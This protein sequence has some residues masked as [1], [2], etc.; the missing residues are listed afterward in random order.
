MKKT[1]R[2]L[3]VAFGIIFALSSYNSEHGNNSYCIDGNCE[4]A[5]ELEHNDEHDHNHENDKLYNDDINLGN[6]KLGISVLSKSKTKVSEDGISFGVHT[7]DTSSSDE[8]Y[9]SIELQ[10]NYSPSGCL[11]DS[12]WSVSDSTALKVTPNAIDSSKCVVT[13]IKEFD[14]EVTVS[15]KSKFFSDICATLKATYVGGF[16]IEVIQGTISLSANRGCAHTSTSIVDSSSA[17]SDFTNY[18][19]VKYNGS[20]LSV[21]EIYSY[22]T[23]GDLIVTTSGDL[24]FVNNSSAPYF[25]MKDLSATSTAG[26]K[27]IGAT[28]KAKEDSSKTGS[29]SGTSTMKI[30]DWSVVQKNR[31]VSYNCSGTITR[32]WNPDYSYYCGTCSRTATASEYG[33]TCGKQSTYYYVECNLCTNRNGDVGDPCGATR[34]SY[35]YRCNRCSY[36]RSYS[37]TCSRTISSDYYYECNSCGATYSSNPGKCT[38]TTYKTCG[39]TNLDRINDASY[40]AGYYWRCYSCKQI[41]DNQDAEVLGECTNTIS[42][43]CGGSV[44]LKSDSTTCGGTY[45]YETYTYTCSGT[46]TSYS[47]TTTCSGTITRKDKGSYSYYC[48]TCKNTSSSTYYNTT[49]GKALKKIEPY[50]CCSVCGK[51]L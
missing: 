3:V 38:K 45:V 39:S 43:T 34:S 6:N 18:F 31:E 35:R 49:C 2:L 40:S 9:G 13:A 22:I 10:A 7:M 4:H 37:G 28:I 33:N 51:E 44:S 46:M 32:T 24:S 47:S 26:S 5:H 36:T 29:I 15:V 19:K 12:I 48:D 27:A 23:S 25:V 20:D 30:G 1:K 42:T 21:S 41:V 16:R 50:D 8:E 17:K 14:G 11:T